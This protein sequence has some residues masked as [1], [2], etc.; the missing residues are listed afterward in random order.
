MGIC[1]T[2]VFL[3]AIAQLWFS[4]KEKVHA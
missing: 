3:L 4:R 2:V 1:Y